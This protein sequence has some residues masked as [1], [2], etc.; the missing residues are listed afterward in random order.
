MFVKFDI[1]DRLLQ[2]ANA[3]SP[4]DVIFEKSLVR[5]PNFIV[6]KLLHPLNTSPSIV[7]IFPSY[8]SCN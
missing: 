3:L 8:T 1:L 7:V 5:F 6:A 4:I 2:P